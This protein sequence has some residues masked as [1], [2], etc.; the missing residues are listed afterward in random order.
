[1]TPATMTACRR[2]GPADVDAEEDRLRDLATMMR[3]P[4]SL[5]APPVPLPL[6]RLG[7]T[8]EDEEER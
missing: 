8:S 5:A 1:V 2:A 6:H 3:E 7:G 4:G